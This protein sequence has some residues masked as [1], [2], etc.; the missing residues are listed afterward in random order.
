MDHVAAMLYA[1]RTR[2]ITGLLTPG[3][4]SPLQKLYLTRSNKESIVFRLRLTCIRVWRGGFTLVLNRIPLL[5]V[6]SHT[7]STDRML[8]PTE[9]L[10]T[11]VTEAPRK[12]CMCCFCA[13]IFP[14][15]GQ[16][17]H[18]LASFLRTS[19]RDRVLVRVSRP[20][21]Y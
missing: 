17:R 18:Q 11:V 14:P 2:M 19:R 5:Q 3:V 8:S 4:A 20:R 21:A 9:E 12:K 16:F 15:E 6:E 1:V 10:H 13:S 7:H